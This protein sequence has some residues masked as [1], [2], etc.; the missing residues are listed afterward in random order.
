MSFLETLRQV[1]AERLATRNLPANLAN[2]LE[3]MGCIDRETITCPFC[4][5][6]IE[7]WWEHTSNNP[8]DGEHGE[9]ECDEC[10]KTYTFEVCIAVSFEMRAPDED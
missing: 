3:T 6:E 5:R 10:G 2:D 7:E 8:S 4:G 9:I 1:E